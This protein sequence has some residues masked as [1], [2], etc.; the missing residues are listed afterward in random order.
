[1][2]KLLEILNDPV[3]QVQLRIK[4]AVIIDAGER[5]VKGTYNLEGNGPL[6]LSTYEELRRIYNFVSLPHYP[7]LVACARNLAGGNA[8]N[9]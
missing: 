1:M 8:T 7:N 4:L 6:A 5:F 3:K 9:N 2:R